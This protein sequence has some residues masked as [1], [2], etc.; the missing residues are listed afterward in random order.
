MVSKPC[1]RPSYS[2]LVS[3][4]SSLLGAVSDSPR[5]DSEL[6]L[7]HVLQQPLAWL[8]VYGD[9]PATPEHDCEFMRLVEQRRQGQ[10]IA[11]LLGYKDFWSLRLKVNQ[12]V[13]IPRPD[14]EVVVEQALQ[15]LNPQSVCK[16]LDL[17]TGSGAIALSIAKERPKAKIMAVDSQPEALE[18]ARNNAL[19][20][21]LDN[22]TF[23]QSNWF[24]NPALSEFDLI[25]A[26][27]PYIQAADPHLVQGDLR[28]EPDTALIGGGDGLDDLRQIINS[29]PAHLSDSGW[30][31]VE[32]GF[33]QHPEV[34]ALFHQRGFVNVSLARDLNDHARCTAGQWSAR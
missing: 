1:P 2:N 6:L 10:P 16:V 25:A 5:I 32:H 33:D 14:T 34:Q 31:V 19:T 18:V 28:F 15:R 9:T 12:H 3:Q 4:A 22:V 26:N 17:G 27:P 7:L 8:L 11:Y 13:L 23:L 20:S 24:D 30:L 29:S 21:A